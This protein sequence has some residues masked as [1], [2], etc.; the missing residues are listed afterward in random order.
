MFAAPNRDFHLDHLIRTAHA[1][2]LASQPCDAALTLVWNEWPIT[3]DRIK[4]NLRGLHSFIDRR[5][6]GQRFHKKPNRSQMWAVVELLDQYPHVH[7]GWKLP[8]PFGFDDLQHIMATDVWLTFAPRGSHDIQPH[9]KGWAGYATKALQ[10]SSQII[11]SDE[12]H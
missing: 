10:D 2:F 7:A 11:V 4:R 9:R 12:F 5:L 6:L 1:E 8:E 3:F